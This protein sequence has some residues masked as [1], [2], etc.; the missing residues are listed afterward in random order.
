[1]GT[2][3]QEI[4]IDRLAAVILAAAICLCGRPALSQ[5][6]PPPGQGDIRATHAI[7]YADCMSLARS[8]PQKALGVAHRWERE[9]GDEGARHCRAIALLNS[10]AYAEA[11]RQLESLASTT[12]KPGKRLKAELLVQ[13]GQA[14]LI[15]GQTERALS[16]QT[17]ALALVGPELEILLDRAITLASTGEYWKAIDD[18]NDVIDQ[19]SRHAGALVLRA[20]AW[21]KLKNLDLARDDIERAIALSPGSIDALLERGNIRSLRGETAAAA[22]DWEAV[23]AARPKSPAADAARE[24]LAKLKAQ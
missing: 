1:M 5:Q 8:D 3:L 16:A 6:A 22:A 21:R 10:G 23:I 19:D 15:A 14:W 12:N 4:R 24:N 11:A 7:A 13:A 2:A 20:T 9:G 17:R 18:L